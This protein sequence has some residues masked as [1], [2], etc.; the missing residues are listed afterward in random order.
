MARPHKPKPARIPQ[1]LPDRDALL[2]FI[3]EHGETDKAA[4]AR[5]FGLKGADR[6]ALRMMMAEMEEDGT[7]SRR[8][9][10]GFAET[11]ALPEV[12]VAVAAERDPDGDLLVKLVKGEDAPL[13]PL[14]PGGDE[15]GPAP[16][17]GDKLLVRFVRLENGEL[18]AR[19]IKR[20]GQSAHRVLGVIRKVRREVRVEP[21]DRRSKDSLVL[22]EPGDLRDGDLV[23]AQ[24]EG[25]VGRY[26][27]KRGKVLEVVGREDEPR[28]ASMIAIHAHGIP[29]GFS[30]AAEAEA[31]AAQP[32]TL[33]GRED[34]RE[35]P[36]ITIDP[37]DAR[38]HD[39]AVYAEPD[40]DEKNP[41][42]WIVWVAIADVAAYVTSGSALD[43]EARDKGNSVY[44]PDRVEP[45]LP[46]R[47]SNGLCSLREGE[48]RAC[49]AVRMVFGAD[50]RK[51]SHR[52]VRGLMRSA[53]KLSYEQAQAAIDGNPDDKTG[54]LLQ[55]VLKPLWTA[56]AT[57]KKGRDARSPL[58]I[59]SLER[60]IVID[61]QGQVVSITPRASLEAHRLIEEFMIQANVCAA[62]TLEQKKIPLIYRIHD[63]PSQE[64]LFALV[65]FLGTLG[66]PWTK[67]EAPRT[68]R[69]NRL[70]DETRDTPH[71]EIVNE[72]VLRTQMQA[73]YSTENIGHYGLNLAKYAHFT[74]PIR[75]YADLIVHRALVSALGLGKDGLSE[76]DVAQMKGTA[77]QITGAERRAMAAERDATDRYIAAFL[78]D[79]VGAEFDGKITGVTRFG[80][81]VR[82]TET[83]A[84]GLVPVSS[85]GGEYFVHDDRAHALVGERSGARWPL[86]MA[87][88]VRLREATPITGGLLFEMLS[89]PAPP[90]P[91]A[92][93][94]RLGVRARGDRRPGGEFRG[95]PRGQARGG[96]AG[97]TP[98]SKGKKKTRGR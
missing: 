71:A 6:R 36:L 79:R 25:S 49:M 68:E 98:K 44:F 51:R 14:A 84:D 3:R 85:L 23:V 64:K 38:D 89:E 86:G 56:Y 5:A 27:P 39:D 80:L 37:A 67:G 90:D 43:R 30:Q 96:G 33:A 81:F 91:S 94:P 48:N 10:R 34:L 87:V 50:G 69:F 42:G 35:V 93:R 4:I 11:G 1:G 58:A 28:A 73:H 55:P 29:T 95:P 59:E 66:L 20:L 92:P 76:R 8:S 7:L 16:G 26:G 88:Q 19:L 31:E 40:N 53:A 9:R 54:P 57:M 82:L 15:A 21:V 2:N 61:A 46:E 45:M 12:G 77:E 74:S 47:L 32:P 13:V 65:D 52:F 72:V 63:A 24:M 41:G 83:G 60:K 62:E 70:L 17:L 22:T 75:R 18:E 97:R 78:S